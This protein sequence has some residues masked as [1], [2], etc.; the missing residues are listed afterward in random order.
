MEY[1]LIMRSPEG[2]NFCTRKITRGLARISVG[3]QDCLYM[4]NL[5]AKEIGDM[6][7]IMLRCNG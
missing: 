6:P 1:F 3:V 4:G 7:K 5:D 2:R